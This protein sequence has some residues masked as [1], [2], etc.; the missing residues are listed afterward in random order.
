MIDIHECAVESLAVSHDGGRIMSG[1]TDDTVRIYDSISG[2]EVM[3]FESMGMAST[4]S[5]CHPMG[6]KLLPDPLDPDKTIHVWDALL[7]MQILHA[8]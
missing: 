2:T 5:L 3:P 1:L 7:G 6:N 8:L 4:Q